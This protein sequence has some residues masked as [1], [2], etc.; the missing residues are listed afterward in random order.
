MSKF[1]YTKHERLSLKGHPDFN[2]KWLHTRISEDP[3]ILGLG[4][5]VLIDSERA[6]ERSGRL[7]APLRRHSALAMTP[8]SQRTRAV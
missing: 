7:D 5:V 8:V 3:T 2:E 1:T 6:Q 4:E